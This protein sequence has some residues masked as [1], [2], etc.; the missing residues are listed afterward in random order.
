MPKTPAQPK[1]LVAGASR[2]IR[3]AVCTRCGCGCDDVD[4]TVE[5]NRVVAARN[6]CALGQP[7]FLAPLVE[8]DPPARVDGREVPVEEA[9]AAAAELLAGARRPLIWGLVHCSSEAQKLAIEIGDRLGGVVDPAAGPNHAAA[10][11]AFQEW[12]EVN[13][14]LG[15]VTLQKSLIVLW[16]V[17]PERTHPRLLERWG[18][19]S[20]D[21]ER[22]IRPG[23]DRA[24]GD[25]LS[26]EG[27]LDLLWTLRELARSRAAASDAAAKGQPAAPGDG[28]AGSTPPGGQASGEGAPAEAARLLDR[29]ATEPHAVLVFDAAATPPGEQHALRALAAT[30]NAVTRVRLFALGGPGNRA[31]ADAV[32]TWQTGFPAGVDFASGAPRANG[33]EFGAARLL[34]RR[35]VDAALVVCSDPADIPSEPAL[36][37]LRDLPLV[38]LDSA[39]NSLLDKARVALRSAPYGLASGGTFF[40][41]DGVALGL[42]PAVTS[43]Y[44]TEADWLSGILS[45]LPARSAPRGDAA[46]GKAAA[47]P[48][49]QKR[50]RT[51]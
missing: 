51:P 41:M 22:V 6:A 14:T 21:A 37:R 1:P 46:S 29:L 26:P 25:R 43:R 27:R 39:A 44:P 8:D 10:V 18:A 3:S 13:T 23:G 45:R 48:K 24:G 38:V 30:L 7:W 35:D 49:R 16:N 12:G 34:A 40:R 2:E 31:G 28:S 5:G 32:L 4:L 36:A 33:G 20:S 50:K 42:R 17:E 47:R 19:V 11:T 9:A 15:E